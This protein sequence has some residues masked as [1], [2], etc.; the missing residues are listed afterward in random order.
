MHKTTGVTI[1][2]LLF[3]LD[4]EAYR[5]FGTYLAELRQH[6]SYVE[7]GIDIMEDI[8]TRIAEHFTAARKADAK[9]VIGKSDVEKLISSMGTA[10]ELRNFGDESSE[11]STKQSK[12]KRLFRSTEDVV[13]AGVAAGIA[14]Y[15]GIDPLFVRLAFVVASFFNGFGILVYVVAWLVMPQA[16]T[17]TD[18]LAMEGKT[19]TLAAIQEKFSRIG[20]GK[21]GKLNDLLHRFG[22]AL[23]WTSSVLWRAMRTLLGVLFFV[24][25]VAGMFFATF[26]VTAVLSGSV[27]KYTDIPLSHFMTPWS[28]YSIAL[29][30]YIVIVI[31][32][33]GFALIGAA[34]IRRKNLFRPAVAGGLGAL[35]IL[36][37]LFS[38]TTAFA[39]ISDATARI[40]RETAAYQHETETTLHA[41]RNLIPKAFT[42]L[43]L[44]GPY[45][46]KIVEG[47]TEGIRIEGV[48]DTIAAIT[49]DETTDGVR[50]NLPDTKR[51]C[52]FCFLTEPRPVVTI[53]APRLD[54]L[55]L[56]NRV[57]MNLSYRGPKLNVL[58]EDGSVRLGFESAD[59]T[60]A[61][62][63]YRATLGGSASTTHLT[64]HDWSALDASGFETATAD[65]HTSGY[66][67][68]TLVVSKQIS[69]SVTEES[70]LTW[71]GDGTSTVVTTDDG[72]TTN[73]SAS[74]ELSFP[75]IPNAPNIPR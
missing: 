43:F 15:L 32:L 70:F 21:K 66:S 74:E 60:L 57:A 51:T 1:Q 61:L 13:I 33:L 31:P 48:H 65:V 10:E 72:T 67:K 17:V 62:R 9:E 54:Q 49:V 35:W 11:R 37:L 2:G 5:M 46:V 44:S 29:G 30:G 8:E 6:F 24:G 38:S 12:K 14:T 63:D 4:E 68:A 16:Q 41:E 50:I 42:R 69:G 36:A 26:G 19:P 71:S 45:D 55:A 75:E 18:K 25:A 27:S 56:D 23:R 40:H 53:T 20:S 7:D 58:T 34:L 47:D 28:I 3:H 52:L 73:T 39:V 64:L 22:K 59:I